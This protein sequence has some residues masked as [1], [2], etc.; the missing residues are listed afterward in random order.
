MKLVKLTQMEEDKLRT[1]KGD[2]EK[3]KAKVLNSRLNL[4]DY[5]IYKDLSNPSKPI[6]LA[7]KHN[8]N[9]HKKEIGLSVEQL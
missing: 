8:P 5:E 9:L 7:L 1:K 6:Y 3:L 4:A 2:L